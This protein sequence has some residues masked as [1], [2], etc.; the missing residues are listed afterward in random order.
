MITVLATGIFFITDLRDSFNPRPFYD[1]SI[2]GLRL[3]DSKMN[4]RQFTTDLRI[5]MTGVLTNESG[6]PWGDVEF[7]C[8]F[9]D[10]GG[11]MIDVA[12]LHGNFTVQPHDDTAFRVTCLP[13]RDTNAYASYRLEITSAKNA[14]TR[15]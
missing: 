1:Q 15:Y 14:H 10:T 13:G 3:L 5:V 6:I 7:E 2:T 4:W 12:N 11:R 8:R 9:F